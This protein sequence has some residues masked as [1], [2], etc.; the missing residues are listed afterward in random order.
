MP[1][2]DELLRSAS[3]PHLSE[4]AA[5][6]L[7]SR[8]DLPSRVIELLRHNPALANRRK[9]LP[10]ITAHPHTPKHLA[11]ALARQMFTFELLKVVQT[12]GAPADIQRLCEDTILMRLESTSLG[13]RLTLA[14]SA[15]GRVAAALLRD[16]EPRIRDAALNNPRMTEPL[17]VEQLRKRTS[18]TQHPRRELNALIDAIQQHPKWS[19][20]RDIRDASLAA[21]EQQEAPTVN[22][23]ERTEREVDGD[24]PPDISDGTV[25]E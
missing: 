4:D 20:R 24:E 8:R 15:T 16:T 12:P 13:E 11:L 18:Q 3:D 23:D 17:I 25:K 14:K 10:A 22:T 2:D 6:Q 19:L 21:L 5:L 9:V 7:L 1:D